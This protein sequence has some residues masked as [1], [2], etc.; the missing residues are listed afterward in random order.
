V[1][2]LYTQMLV[3]NAKIK[4]SLLADLSAQHWVPKLWKYVLEKHTN[5]SVSTIIFRGTIKYSI[6]AA[7]LSG[8]HRSIVPVPADLDAGHKKFV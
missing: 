2:Y 8:Q 3:H 4:M 1:Q 7:D 5:T 6:C